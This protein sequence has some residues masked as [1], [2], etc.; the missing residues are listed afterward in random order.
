M[1]EVPLTRN[2]LAALCLLGALSVPAA[3]PTPAQACGLIRVPVDTK[4]EIAAIR[5]ALPQAKLTDPE[6]DKVM[7][8]LATDEKGTEAR[9]TSDF[10]RDLADTMRLLGLERIFLK[11][12][13]RPMR[14]P[15]VT[16]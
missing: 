9:M 4:A 3:A 8:L 16:S 13:C 2:V 1:R 15:V 14:I 10:E 6:R 7:Q 12:S 5:K 11:G